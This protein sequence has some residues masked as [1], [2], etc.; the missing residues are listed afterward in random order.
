MK[1]RGRKSTNALSVVAFARPEIEPPSDLSERE[2]TIFREIVRSKPPD[3]FG[4]PH[5]ALVANLARAYDAADRVWALLNSETIEALVEREGTT[6]LGRLLA[7][8][9]RTCRLA[10]SLATKLRLTHQSVYRAE[11]AARIPVA[12]PTLGKPWLQSPT[13]ESR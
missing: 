11:T 2:T 1:S 7:M 13:G 12:P 9:D 8:Y 4:A 5:V 6:A 3:Y 10:L